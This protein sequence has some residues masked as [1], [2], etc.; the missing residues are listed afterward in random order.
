MKIIPKKKKK[1]KKRNYFFL[2]FPSLQAKLVN[3][4]QKQCNEA[5]TKYRNFFFFFF[6]S[7][8]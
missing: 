4:D 6:K 1:K 5:S 3:V 2:L 7:F 8:D